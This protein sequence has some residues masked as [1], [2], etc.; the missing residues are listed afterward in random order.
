MT[1][2]RRFDRNLVVIGAGTGGLIAALV[3]AKA[4]AKITLVEAADMGGDCLNTGCVPS[5]ALIHAARLAAHAR[6][7]AAMGL[8]A[9]PGE[10]DTQAAMRHVRTAIE[11]VAPHD[12]QARYEGFGVDVRRGRA[13]IVSPWSV[14]V[15]GQTLTTRAIVIATGSEPTTPAIPGLDDY[16]TS[17]TFWRLERLPR[18]LL[19][20]GGGPIAC[21][22]AQACA[23]LGVAVTIVQ[24]APR[25]LEREDDDVSAL[26]RDRLA[27]EGVRVLTDAAAIRADAD[28]LHV[29]HDGAE[30]EIGFDR[31]LLATGRRPRTAGLGLEALGI[32]LAGDGT[33]DTNAYLQTLHPS[34][35]A[36][37]DV[38]GPWQFT[39]AAAHQAWHASINA[40]FGSLHRIRPGR[41]VM[42]F[43]T[44]TDPEI[45]RA[46]LNRR[47]AQARGIA[48]DVARHD[49]RDLD[50]A[51]VDDARDGFVEFLTPPGNDRILGV[52]IA[53]PR[54]GEML[55]EIVLAMQQ[56]IG[57]KRLFGAI[58]AYPTYAEANRD[59][60]GA[61]RTAHA[62]AW[63]LAASSRY[64]RWRRGR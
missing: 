20:L 2:P 3:A 46:G 21:E 43:V 16:L 63:A 55:A 10:I 39:H 37:G 50:R 47:Q 38:A 13:R 29:R 62:P 19:I 4:G 15:A 31:I 27:R 59:A 54:A 28:T 5:K 22:L 52:T 30:R 32:P 64:L 48:V 1:R 6:E 17:E 18:R 61:W 35:Y 56:G 40:L 34:V 36:C 33:I 9:P 57:L 44:Y 51:I 11:T 58:H 26:V 24:R 23:R 14:D 25:L 45:A 7:A 12:S 8:V 42:P 49:L 41:A 60:A 53:A